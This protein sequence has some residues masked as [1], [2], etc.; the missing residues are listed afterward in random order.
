MRDFLKWTALTFG[1]LLVFL[2]VCWIA[3]GADF[4][5]YKWFAP[6]Y[7]QVR[8]ETFEQSKAYNQGMIQELENLCLEYGKADPEHK[9]AIASVVRHRY[10]DFDDARVPSHLQSCLANMRR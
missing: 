4:F 8:R 1:C 3:Q 10:A 7:E 9:A 5:L 2:G 6:K